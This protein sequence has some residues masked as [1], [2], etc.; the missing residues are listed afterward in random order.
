LGLPDAE[1]ALSNNG[2]QPEAPNPRISGGNPQVNRKPLLN[3]W[4]VF[5]SY[6]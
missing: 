2:E 6:Q 3:T 4:A 1:K 5:A